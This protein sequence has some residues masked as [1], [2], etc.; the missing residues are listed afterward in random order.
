MTATTPTTATTGLAA[1]KDRQM[2]AWASGDYAVIGTTLQPV[3]EL[4]A[5]A[6]DLRWGEQV[7][8]VAA[9]NGN[10]T[11]AAARRG[12]RV[13]STDY[14]PA[15]LE[16]GA[17]RARAERLD[18]DFQVADAEA[19]PFADA[20]FDAV[21]SAFGVMFSPDQARA[22][23]ELVRVCRPGGRIGLA[24]W[25]P[26][27]FV[28]QMFKVLGRFVPPPAGLRP[29][30]LWGVEAHLRSLFG[31]H[32]AAVAVEP[33]LFHFRYR[34]AAHFV[35]VFREYYGPVHKAFAALSTEDAQALELDLTA[36]L[37][38][39]NRAGAGSLVVPGEYLEVVIT[40]R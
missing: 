39:M 16:R 35:E 7:L 1:L 25:T 8:D 9:G 30:A 40:R 3:G 12:C 11:L 19:L 33:R 29:P 31:E 10:A 21:L 36:L 38:G 2:A 6:C 28:G 18:V 13:T 27:G 15:L 23:S 22:P 20:A 24:N 37:D 17:E 34:S 4:L 32:A 5:E 26:E 14:V